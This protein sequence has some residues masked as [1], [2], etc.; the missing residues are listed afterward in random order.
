M[1]FGCTV[2][3][4][5]LHDTTRADVADTELDELV[6]VTTLGDAGAEFPCDFADLDRPDPL[7]DVA[8]YGDGGA[9]AGGGSV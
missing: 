2:G 6:T 3:E 4:E 7:A 1:S 5:P 8:A 9:L